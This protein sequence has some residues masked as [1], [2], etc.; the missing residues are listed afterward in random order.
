MKPSHLSTYLELAIRNRTPV[1]ITGAPGIGKS[2]IVGQAAAKAGYELIVEHPVVADPTDYK[3]IPWVDKDG[4]A[5]FVPIGNLARMMQATSP[6]VVLL[7][8]IGQAM[9]AVQ[10]AVMQLLLARRVN[11]KLIPDCVTFLAATNRRTDRAGVTGLLEPVK[12]RFVSIINL[13]VDLEDWVKWALAN[14]LPTELIA[15]IRFRPGCCMTLL[16]PPTL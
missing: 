14:N 10:A 2:D 11:D 5:N 9:L 12:S 6:T 4:N 15:F 1:L 16:P 8:D 7:D 13:D 3:G